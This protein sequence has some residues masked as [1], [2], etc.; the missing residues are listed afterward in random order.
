[1]FVAI[2]RASRDGDPLSTRVENAQDRKNSNSYSIPKD[3]KIN[4]V[5]RLRI[6]PWFSKLAVPW[7][8]IKYLSVE[9]QAN[10]LMAR[11]GFGVLV[12]HLCEPFR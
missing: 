8:L 10:V 6:P 3:S 4:L 12:L 2:L 11:A 7:T 1:M 5:W 9:N